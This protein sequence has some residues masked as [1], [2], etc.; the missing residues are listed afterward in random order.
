MKNLDLLK[1][2]LLSIPDD[3][4]CM[5]WHRG[6]HNRGYGKVWTGKRESVHR[7]A[8]KLAVGPIPDG[9]EVLHKCDNPPCFRPSHLILLKAPRLTQHTCLPERRVSTVHLSMLDVFSRRSDPDE[10]VHFSCE[11]DTQKRELETVLSQYK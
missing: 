4:S 1:H 11:T 5:E 7:V 2:L 6:R 9:F 8:Y 3:D 10:A